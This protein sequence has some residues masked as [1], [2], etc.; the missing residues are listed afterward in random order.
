MYGIWILVFIRKCEWATESKRETIWIVQQ[1]LTFVSSFLF[2]CSS[3]LNRLSMLVCQALWQKSDHIK[4]TLFCWTT[5]THIT[6]LQ[7]QIT[8]TN[9]LTLSNMIKL[10]RNTFNVHWPTTQWPCWK[11]KVML[12]CTHKCDVP[13]EVKIICLHRF[14]SVSF[15]LIGFLLIDF[16]WN[17]KYRDRW[18]C[19]AGDQWGLCQYC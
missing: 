16:R 3:S 11:P 9:T 15:R 19:W 10:H 5:H 7:N 2:L 4:W 12:I 1:L 8:F 14:Y 18:W 17:S 13:N 6:L